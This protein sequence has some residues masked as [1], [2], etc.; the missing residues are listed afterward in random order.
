MQEF[1]TQCIFNAVDKSNCLNQGCRQM[2]HYNRASEYDASYHQ[3]TYSGLPKKQSFTAPKGLGNP[4]TKQ[5]IYLSSE[6]H[7][8]DSQGF[9]PRR[10]SVWCT[11]PFQA[12]CW[13]PKGGEGPSVFLASYSK[14]HSL[15]LDKNIKQSVLLSPGNLGGERCLHRQNETDREAKQWAKEAQKI[16]MWEWE[17]AEGYRDWG[18]SSVVRA[19]A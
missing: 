6:T 3:M 17:K 16:A 14:S 15:S 10:R 18:Y 7:L 1:T 12:N 19:H 4:W 8:I 13:K 9:V 2:G 11:N 5:P